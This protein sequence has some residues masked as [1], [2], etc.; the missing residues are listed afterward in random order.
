MKL[1]PG[2]HDGGGYDGNEHEEDAAYKQLGEEIVQRDF[3]FLI[4]LAERTGNLVCNYKTIDKSVV[5]GRRREECYFQSN[6]RI[7]A[8]ANPS[9]NMQSRPITR[10]ITNG[11]IIAATIEGVEFARPEKMTTKSVAMMKLKLPAL[12][13]ASSSRKPSSIA[14]KPRSRSKTSMLTPENLEIKKPI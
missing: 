2:G 4:V 10:T 11:T 5:T 1:E 7:L 3:L 9:T 8:N 12:I 14:T 13:S 6:W